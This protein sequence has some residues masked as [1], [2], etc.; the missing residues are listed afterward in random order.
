MI[1]L[2][3]LYG[4]Q[5]VGFYPGQA[6]TP[7]ERYDWGVQHLEKKV[8]RDRFRMFFAV[9]EFEAWLLSQPDI[10][11][12]K[13]KNA[14]P[15]KIAQPENVNFDEPPAKLLDR[16]YKAQTQRNYKKTTYGKELFKKLD[17]AEAVKKCPRL[18]QMLQEM[19][20]L[21]KEAGQ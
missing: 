1:G 18:K 8:G 6:N 15:A 17:P 2:I 21:A 19:L 9:H 20:N 12:P 7:D 14:L 16:I 5:K 11:L 13:I 3:D 10:F 4:P